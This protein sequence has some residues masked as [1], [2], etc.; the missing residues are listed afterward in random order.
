MIPRMMVDRDMTTVMGWIRIG[1]TITDGMMTIKRITK[2]KIL[3]NMIEITRHRMIETTGDHTKVT[4]ITMIGE[5]MKKIDTII[6]DSMMTDE[7]IIDA[8]R[9][10]DNFSIILKVGRRRHDVRQKHYEKG[11]VSGPL[12]IGPRFVSLRSAAT[13]SS[14]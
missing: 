4:D 11:E 8:L 5:G 12:V 14:D 6:V 2:E 13:E 3:A 1:M 10:F 7:M 9:H